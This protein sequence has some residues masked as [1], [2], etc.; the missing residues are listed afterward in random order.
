[1]KGYKGFDKDWKCKGL[2]Y[3][4]GEVVNHKGEKKLCNNGLHF[5]ENPLDVLKY[6][7]PSTSVFAEVDADDVTNETHKEDSKRVCGQIVVKSQINL[8]SLISIGVSW[9]IAKGKAATSGDRSH[10]A[11]SGDNSHSATSGYNSHSATSGDY[12]PSAISG[13]N[14]HSATSGDDSIAAAIGEHSQARAE[15]GSWIV[16]AEYDKEHHVVCVKTARVDG[17]KIK[18]DTWYTLK[19]KKLVAAMEKPGDGE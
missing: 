9:L 18:A 19:G 14:S 5:C 15:K 4:I 10:S 17:K 3:K 13:D 2:Q 12:S 6:Y 7:S 1:M 11:T 8:A 16:L